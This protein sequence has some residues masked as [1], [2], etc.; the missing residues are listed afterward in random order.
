MAR[1]QVKVIPH[2]TT[3]QY[4]I[5]CHLQVVALVDKGIDI[6][7][8]IRFMAEKDDELRT[9]AESLEDATSVSSAGD[10]IDALR[11]LGVGME[12][13]FKEKN[14]PSPTQIGRL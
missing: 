10:L 14:I 9:I 12:R 2:M 5:W 4:F 1:R 8:A 7:S 3:Q 11:L 13:L 6:Q